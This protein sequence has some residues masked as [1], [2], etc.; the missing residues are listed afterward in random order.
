MGRVAP[1]LM[2]RL[3]DDADIFLNSSVIDNQP[4][5]VLEA[6]AA[7]LPVVSTGVG[8][9]AALVRDGETG[10]RVP[11]GDPGAMAEAVTALL[12]FPERAAAMAGRARQEVERYTWPSVRDAWAAVYTGSGTT[13]K[14]WNREHAAVDGR[15][16]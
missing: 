10:M 3:Y 13:R 16:P 12:Q 9:L 5:S 1:Q 4:V 7:G 8:D 2:P 6:F 11:S 14:A 15:A